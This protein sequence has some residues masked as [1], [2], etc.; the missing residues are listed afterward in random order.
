MTP[1]F[2]IPFTVSAG[3]L[4][5]VLL[6]L[7]VMGGVEEARACFSIVAGKSATADGS[8]LL[9]HNEDNTP[10][11]LTGII[12]V[13]R[14]A[15]QSTAQVVLPDGGRIP[16]KATTYGYLCACLPYVDSADNV[17]NEY[18]VAVASNYCPSREDKPEITG[19]GIGSPVLRHL[20]AQRAKTAR[21]AVQLVGSLVQKFGY[22]S[23]GR[24]LL[25][26]DPNEGW[27]LG[28]V[29]GRHWA[30]ARVPDDEIAF[31]ANSYTIHG[32][33]FRD[34]ENFSGSPGLVA[35]AQSRGWYDPGKG[36]FDFEKA[37]ADPQARVHPG[38]LYRQW[39]AMSKVASEAMVI[40][41]NKTLPFSI[42]PKSKIAARTLFSLLRDHYERTPVWQVD[43][44]TDPTPHADPFTICN[45]GTN[46]SS[47]YQL[48]S[49][50]PVEI[51]ALWWVAMST[52][53]SVPYVPI[54][55]GT[56]DIGS[57]LGFET[58]RDGMAIGIGPVFR[59]FDGIKS[60]V[61][62]DYIHRSPVLK[63]ARD[64]LENATLEM[65]ASLENQA[66]EKWSQDKALAREMVTL[67]SKG[68]LARATEQAQAL[69]EQQA[70]RHR[71]ETRVEKQSR[72]HSLPFR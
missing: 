69:S 56:R 59:G 9:G 57:D 44:A 53:C 49:H 2:K 36:P 18:G 33:D 14:R 39:S 22:N 28:L 40:P 27:L 52:P 6:L 30:A 3:S 8:V 62:K 41:Q 70:V 47:V 54:Y 25:I 34:R 37:F 29:K 23:T 16:Q 61:H 7:L 63:Q 12:R 35:Y 66:K 4:R 13:K 68:A 1:I 20:I 58:N 50:L 15:H 51:G 24:T 19:G 17:L 46:Y 67:F 26:C 42:K 60:W 32:I 72:V 71:N 48:R 31:L 21:E 5:F 64:Q 10:D 55:L 43:P 11:A 38:N 45:H 65:Q